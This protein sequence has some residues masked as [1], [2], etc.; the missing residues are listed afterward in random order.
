MS[1]IIYYSPAGVSTGTF[2]CS[3]YGLGEMIKN[4]KNPVGL[5]IGLAEGYTTRFLMESNDTL[6]LYCVDPYVNYIDWNG[7]NLNER[8]N[9]YQQFLENTKQFS[10]RIKFIR[11]FSDD[12]VSDIEDESLDFIFIDGLHTYDQ[13]TKDMTNYYS[14]VKPGGIFS[15]HDYRVIKCINDAVNDFAKKMD[16]VV[17]ET[18]CDVWYWYK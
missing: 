14:K 9:V 17:L 2:K 7:N 8:E 18:E 6:T 1:D 16:K 12:A 11:K 13:V 5:E 15:G 4:V 10:N 3:G